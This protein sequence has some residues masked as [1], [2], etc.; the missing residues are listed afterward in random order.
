MA[1]N[2]EHMERKEFVDHLNFFVHPSNEV[3]NPEQL[4][5]RSSQLNQLR[6]AF[7]TNGMN[8]FVWGLRGVG[9]TSLVHTACEKFSDTV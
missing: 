5:G 9:K 3:S 4:K 8:A 6:D 7:E 1:K 2:L